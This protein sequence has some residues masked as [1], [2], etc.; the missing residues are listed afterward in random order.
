MSELNLNI[1]LRLSLINGVI[2]GAI[3]AWFYA[4]A[5]GRGNEFWPAMHFHPLNY[6][7]MLLV[8]C[9]NTFGF[10]AW[11]GYCRPIRRWKGFLMGGVVAIVGSFLCSLVMGVG[12]RGLGSLEA[13]TLFF[14]PISGVVGAL[15]GLVLAHL[16]RDGASVA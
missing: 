11:L 3:A 1:R 16:L 12:T 2:T 5:A 10:L 9:L 14:I 7:A 8:C 13:G 15:A 6:A 4:Q